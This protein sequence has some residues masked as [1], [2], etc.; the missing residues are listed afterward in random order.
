MRRWMRFESYNIPN[1][2]GQ[3]KNPAKK[4]KKELPVKQEGNRETWEPSKNHISVVSN[5]AKKQIRQAQI[6][7]YWIQQ[8]GN[9][10]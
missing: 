8:S 3:G 5:A 10:H 7:V 4:T 1:F 2:R 9:H 6:I